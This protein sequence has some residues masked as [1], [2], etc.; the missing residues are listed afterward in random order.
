MS[1]FAA[2]AGASVQQD[3]FYVFA[4]PQ[5][6]YRVIRAGAVIVKGAYATK[7]HAI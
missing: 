3:R 5:R 7:G 6:V 2:E 1:E 4:S